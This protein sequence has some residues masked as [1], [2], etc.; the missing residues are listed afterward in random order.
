MLYGEELKDLIKITNSLGLCPLVEV[1]DR[2]E[3]GK[4]VNAGAVVIGINNRNLRDFSVSLD[5]AM[6]II[7][8]VPQDKT[9]VIESGIKTHEDVKKFV[10]KGVNTFLVG[11]A[12]MRT[13][14]I[15]PALKELING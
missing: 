12:L 7:E 9:I 2:A 15:I 10:N 13:S 11:E 6:S 4:A 1:H 3:L 14:N 5:T 8:T